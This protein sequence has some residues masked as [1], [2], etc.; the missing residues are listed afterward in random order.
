MDSPWQGVNCRALSRL[1][2]LTFD[3]KADS[4]LQ[5]VSIFHRRVSRKLLRV[6]WIRRRIGNAL[7]IDGSGP[8]CRG[9]QLR[10]L[11]VR[12]GAPKAE[13]VWGRGFGSN[14]VSQ[15]VKER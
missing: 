6:S 11:Q 14:N 4:L 8:V 9:H 13:R 7:M 3:R 12:A 1:M 10:R 2:Q 5:L 15:D